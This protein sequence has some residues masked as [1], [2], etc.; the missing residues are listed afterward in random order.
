MLTVA[1]VLK[2]GGIYDAS[3]VSRL[4][5]G[6]ARHLP[7]AHQFV[8]LSDVD[9]PCERIPLAH[10]WPGWWSKIELFKLPGPVLF[11][12]LDTAIVGDLTG[13]AEIATRPM[14]TVLQD[15][16]RPHGY[17]SGM[18]A[19]GGGHFDNVEWLYLTFARYAET[20]MKERGGDQAFI[21]RQRPDNVSRWQ[22]VLPGQVVSYKVHCQG[23]Y[24]THFNEDLQRYVPAAI[25]SG[26]RVVC[27]HGLPKFADMSQHDPVRQAWEMAA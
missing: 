11:F 13:A 18:M 24:G 3:W 17:G 26:A 23:A 27:L 1:C 15:F 7:I 2:S 25:P 19:W 10:D 14:F 4:R 22:D 20:E 9:V 12:D 6:V 21:E 5:A 16:Y 8:C